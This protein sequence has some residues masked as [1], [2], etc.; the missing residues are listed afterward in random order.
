M[1]GAE[2]TLATKKD[3]G[4]FTTIATYS[5][6]KGYVIYRVKEKKF[7][8]LQVKLSSTKPFKLYDL[9]LEVYLGSY[10]KR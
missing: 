5:N 2:I 4:T 10:V 1:L 9:A 7:K 8:N 6:T 3:N